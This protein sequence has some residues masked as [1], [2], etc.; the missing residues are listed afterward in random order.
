MTDGH[1][2]QGIVKAETAQNA[3]TATA[4]LQAPIG[5]KA[6]VEGRKFPCQNVV[7]L[8]STGGFHACVQF[9]FQLAEACL[10]AEQGG[11]GVVHMVK[12]GFVL[13]SVL[14]FGGK[15]ALLGQNAQ[16]LALGQ[17]HLAL[18]GL[19]FSRDH[20]EQGGLAAAVDADDA[21]LVLFVQRKRDVFKYG[22]GAE[23]ECQVG[24]ADDDHSGFP[25]RRAQG[26]LLERRSP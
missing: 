15:G 24:D 20:F 22:C 10:I 2:H 17:I 16:G 6:L 11:K 26:G 4:E 13:V 14:A 12:G 7:G 18:G 21:Q 1:I 9:V 19:V 5:N 8:L 25:L 23:P 3:Q